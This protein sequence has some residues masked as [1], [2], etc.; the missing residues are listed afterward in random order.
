M[1][2]NHQVYMSYKV[3]SNVSSPM[4]NERE[5]GQFIR[6]MTQD[7]LDRNEA[8]LMRVWVDGRFQSGLLVSDGGIMPRSEPTIPAAVW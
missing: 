5:C 2:E 6:H 7:H 3:G 8:V 1:N 4:M